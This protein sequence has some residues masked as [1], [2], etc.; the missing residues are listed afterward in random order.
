[1]SE[2][3]PP[4]TDDVRAR[5]LTF[6]AAA[7]GTLPED[8]LPRALRPFARFT[9]SRRARAAAGALATALE[10]DPEFR[11]RV[12][13]TVAS[14]PLAAAVGAGAVPPAADPAQAAALAYLLRPQ[15]WVALIEQ[16]QAVADIRAR[17]VADDSAGQ[18]VRLLTEQL[19]ASRAEVREQ[20]RRF[21][22]DS[23]QAAAA[24]DALRRDLR[25]LGKKSQQAAAESEQ[26]IAGLAAERQRWAAT[27]S[28]LEADLRRLRVQL[29]AAEAVVES[30]RRGSREGRTGEDMRLWL[31]LDT[32]VN[33]AQGLRRELALTPTDE[34]PAD[35]VL[36]SAGT[37]TA[38]PGPS[39]PLEQLLAMP[40]AHLI[41][42]G[43]N[44]TKTG[45]GD[46]PLEAQRQR[47]VSRLGAVAAQT[48]AEVTV[49]FDG[50]ERLP[51]APASPRG[52]RVRFSDIGQTADDLIGLLV[53][54]EPLG[55]P[56]VVVSTD[57]EVA[58]AARG[59]GAHPVASAALLAHL[60]HA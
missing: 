33:A 28:R 11:H 6:A 52:V 32:L 54:A 23:A 18:Q 48:G 35:S 17:R 8:E 2:T 5:V 51:V 22:A 53:G 41:I 56:V 3:P 24:A 27:Q 45:Y 55:R 39:F 47:L 40:R 25:E 21:R 49:V 42:D 13:G 44:V 60:E 12:A 14:D 58:D 46:L 1:M 29:G 10:D 37:P 38:A 36:A 59:A 15:G 34:R 26:A 7:L 19:A 20:A 57:G 30:A 9:P 16:A 4:L 31:L 50:A 43:Y